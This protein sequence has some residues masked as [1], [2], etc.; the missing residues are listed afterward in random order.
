ME[1][2]TY[3]QDL[4]RYLD[5]F[6]TNYAAFETEAFLQTYNGIIAVL[7]PLRQQRQEAIGI[8]GFFLEKIKQSPLTSSDLR[9]LTIQVLITYFESEA[10]TDGQS[11]RAYGY[12]RGLRPVKQDIPFFENHLVPL[13]FNI[14]SLNDNFRLKEFLLGEIARYLTKFGRRLNAGISPEE[15]Q[16]MSDPLKT[17][18]LTRRRVELGTGLLADRNSLEFHLNRIDYFAKLS[19]A[20]KLSEHFLKDWHYLKTT[21]FWNR[22]GD[23][24]SELGGK[25]KG[26]FSSFGYLRLILNQRNPAYVYY[27][28][29]IIIFILLAIYVPLK[30]QD[31]SQE[32]LRDFQQRTHQSGGDTGR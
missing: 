16:A 19:A 31:Y 25:L 23:F 26:A 9:Q 30:W 10:D 5:T 2:K 4:F 15:F 13:L 22:L 6:E 20:N 3:I 14:G 24:L 28:V 29:I 11:N 7:N 17:L 21:S 8:D 12:C 32:Q 18:E 1:I 27:S